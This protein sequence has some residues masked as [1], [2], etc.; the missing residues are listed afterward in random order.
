M[1]YILA[2][3][4]LKVGDCVFAKESVVFKPGNSTFLKI[5]PS[6]FAL[7]QLKFFQIKVLSLLERRVA[8]RR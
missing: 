1:S 4:G 6:V 3:E 5:S 7:I 8:T 2:P